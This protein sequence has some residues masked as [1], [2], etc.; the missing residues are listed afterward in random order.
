MLLLIYPYRFNSLQSF[1]K[2]RSH[3]S[4]NLINLLPELLQIVF[5]FRRIQGW[6]NPS[7]SMDCAANSTPIL[8]LA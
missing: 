8:P 2:Q 6:I 3:G 4:V 1:L 5:L 7:S